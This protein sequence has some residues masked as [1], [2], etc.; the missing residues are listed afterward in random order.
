MAYIVKVV[1]GKGKNKSTFQSIPLPN[2][3]RVKRYIR[4]Q[5]AIKSNT[6]IKVTNT[7]T[8]KT[9]TGKESSFLFGDF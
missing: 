8:K 1:T 5:P 7:R 9:K 3:E 4:R 2:K 6:N